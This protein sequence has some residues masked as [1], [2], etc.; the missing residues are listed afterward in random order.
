LHARIIAETELNRETGRQTDEKER[1]RERERVGESEREGGRGMH[2]D[3]LPVHRVV[4]G[5]MHEKRVRHVSNKDRICTGVLA[6]A[7][8]HQVVCNQV[9]SILLSY[10][11]AWVRSRCATLA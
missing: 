11:S 5:V 8:S 6:G 7:A 9:A 4:N 1:E 2:S 10:S 3:R